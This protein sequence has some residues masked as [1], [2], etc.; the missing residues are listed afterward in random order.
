MVGTVQNRAGHD[1]L[2]QLCSKDLKV[3]SSFDD[4]SF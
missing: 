3:L 1:H 4:D 2:F